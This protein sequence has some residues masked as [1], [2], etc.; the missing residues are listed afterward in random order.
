MRGEQGIAP[1]V[2][3]RIARAFGVGAGWLLF[4]ETTAGEAVAEPSSLYGRA[5]RLPVVGAGGAVELPV[6]ASVYRVEDDGLEPVWHRG[7]RLLVVRAEKGEGGPGI[8]RRG[9]TAWRVFG[10][11]L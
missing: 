2:A 11:I 5:V 8:V 7:Q 6:G 3:E 10:V 9:R 1:A 4:G